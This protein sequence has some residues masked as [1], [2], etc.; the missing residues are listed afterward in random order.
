M[1]NGRGWF[2]LLLMGDEK[3]IRVAIILED[4][5]IGGAQ[6]VVSEL[7]QNLNQ[8][9]I[10]LLVLCLKKRDATDLAEDVEKIADV[11]YLNIKGKNLI[12]NYARV[13]VELRKFSP[14]VVHAHL[15]GQ[16]Y[17]VPWGLLHNVPVIITAHTKPEKAF[18]KKIEW[19]INYGVNHRRIWVVAVSDE[20]LYLVKKYFETSEQQF[21]CI[22][23]GINTKK[24]YRADHSLFTFINVARQDENKNQIAIIRAFQ[25]LYMQNKDIRLILAGDGPCHTMLVNETKKLGLIDAIDLPGSVGNVRDYY[26]ISDVYVQASHREAMP[27]SVLEALAAGLPIISTDVG[28]LSDVVKDNGF[29]I[30]DDNDKALYDTMGKVATL[31]EIELK[32]MISVSKTISDR[33]SSE[34]MAQEYTKLYFRVGKRVSE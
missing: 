17:A 26:A 20:N 10:K 15:V 6:R 25:K 21:L 18:I 23:N 16:L 2:L 5:S 11:R 7:V 31:P 27:M 12:K 30:P 3:M 32:K 33:Y 24:F 29:L 14:D 28:G 19:L 8:E 1:G 4:F 22:N 34:K 13:A 9:K